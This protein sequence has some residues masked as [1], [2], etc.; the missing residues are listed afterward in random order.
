MKA[1]IKAVTNPSSFWKTNGNFFFLFVGFETIFLFFGR[2]KIDPSALASTQM[3]VRPY[4]KKL[5]RS[6]THQIR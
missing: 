5:F 2:H 4:W 1:E 3:D 6:S